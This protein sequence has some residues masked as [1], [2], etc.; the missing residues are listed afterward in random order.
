[1]KE[2]TGQQGNNSYNLYQMF[3]IAMKVGLK[4]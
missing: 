4:S 2:W 1:M 3:E